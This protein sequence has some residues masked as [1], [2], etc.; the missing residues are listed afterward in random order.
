R[1]F[2]ER[3]RSHDQPAFNWPVGVM[4]SALNSW[5][6]HLPAARARLDRFRISIRRYWNPRPPVAGF[7]VLPDPGGVDRY[8]DDNAWMVL[9]LLETH[10]L[11]GDP[12][13]LEMARKA[14]DY[15]L[16]GE[17]ERLG[18]GIYWRE[19]DKASKNTCSNSPTAY[20]AFRFARETGRSDY[21]AR[22]EPILRWTLKNLQDPEDGLMWDNIDLDGRIEKTK[23]SYNTALTVDSLYESERLGNRPKG[24]AESLFK[25]AWAHWFR[26]DG[27]MV[28]T[29]YFAH[30][31]LRSGLERG[32]V[33]ESDAR[34]ILDHMRKSATEGRFGGRWDQGPPPADSKFSMMH[35]AANLVAL[36]DIYRT[37]KPTVGP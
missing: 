29:S 31:L 24:E 12:A 32:W 7:D 34:A 26:P 2:Y 5:A 9:A 25:R 11:T 8:Y 28:C 21:A 19:S 30:L 4:L 35:Q 22:A 1:E 10:R 13:D 15:S 37:M 33:A 6:P 23:W 27:R 18:G 3:G 36:G 20:A 17:S 16:S 14:L